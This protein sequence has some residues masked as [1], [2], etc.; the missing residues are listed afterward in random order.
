[1]KL[2]NRA[3][4]SVLSH[5]SPAS[6]ALDYLPLMGMF[7]WYRPNQNFEC[8]ICRVGL[9]EWQGKDG[10]CAL[11]VWREGEVSPLEQPIDEECKLPEEARNTF[12]LPESFEIYSYDCGRHRVSANCVAKNG[13]WSET[14]ITA[15]EIKTHL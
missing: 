8:P 3:A 1:M 2:S 14:H 9:N 10:P 15:V 12:R 7:D 13:V 6:S 5:Y 4:D 11:F